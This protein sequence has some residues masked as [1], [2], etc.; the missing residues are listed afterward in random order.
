MF[1]ASLGK[2][3]CFLPSV[4]F[5]PCG[6]P[7]TDL[8]KTQISSIIS[9]ARIHTVILGDSIRN[10]PLSDKQEITSITFA[11]EIT[12]ITFAEL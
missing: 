11:E 5:W 12:S 2:L 10:Y 3:A 1:T 7:L 9:I 8:K 6:P 4:G